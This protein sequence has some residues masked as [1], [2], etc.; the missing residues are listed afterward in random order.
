MPKPYLGHALVFLHRHKL[1]VHAMN[2]QDGHRELSVVD[3]ITFRPVLAAHHGSQDEGRH[4][5]R[6]ALLQ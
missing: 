3:L 1:V 5:E 2:E 4:V 6:I